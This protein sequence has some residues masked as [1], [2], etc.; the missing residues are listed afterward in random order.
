VNR[1]GLAGRLAGVPDAF[2]FAHGRASAI[3]T[4]QRGH[5]P[6]G[7][8]GHAEGGQRTLADQVRRA[9]QQVATLVQ[10]GVDLLARGFATELGGGHARQGGVGQLGLD[11][12]LAQ[13]QLVAGGTGRAAQRFAGR[14]GGRLEVRA[15]LGEVALDVFGRVRAHLR[16]SCLGCAGGGSARPSDHVA[17]VGAVMAWRG[18]CRTSRPRTLP[19]S[20]S[21]TSWRGGSARV[22]RNE[23]RSSTGPALVAVITSPGRRPL[24]AARLPSATFSTST[25]RPRAWRTLSGS[26]ARVA[27]D[28]RGSRLAPARS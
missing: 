2:P 6:A 13:A 9:V 17:G 11:V 16:I 15:G 1:W 10:Q 5:Q 18:Y 19:R 28:R 21:S 3:A 14:T 8:E 23:L 25:P 7:S 24:P 4:A 27:P 12:G 20:I 26:S 22:V